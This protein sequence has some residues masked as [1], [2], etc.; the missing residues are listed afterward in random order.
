VYYWAI[1]KYLK[2]GKEEVVEAIGEITIATSGII[3]R[4]FFEL[5]IEKIRNGPIA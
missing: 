4:K 2:S 3:D 1:L 5:L